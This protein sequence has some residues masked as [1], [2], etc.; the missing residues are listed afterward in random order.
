[1][2][3]K[4]NIDELLKQAEE[5]IEKEEVKEEDTEYTIRLDLNEI[6]KNINKSVK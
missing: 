4:Q 3:A 5:K 6:Q 2:L 1:M